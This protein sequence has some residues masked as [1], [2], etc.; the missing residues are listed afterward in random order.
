MSFLKKIFGQS[1][2]DYAATVLKNKGYKI[3]D[4][5]F[6]TKVGEI[7]IIASVGDCLVFIEVKARKDDK[8]GSPLE[9]VGI[10]KQEIIRKVSMEYLN[11]L[12][13]KGISTEDMD[14]RYDVVGL[15]GRTGNFQ[16]EHI[17]GAF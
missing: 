6:N 14:I 11:M 10:R 17:E 7:D 9:A 4:R 1:G 15:T 13:S 8:F 12:N 5:N 16:V 3:I 2:E